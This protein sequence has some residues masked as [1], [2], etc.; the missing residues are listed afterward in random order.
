MTRLGRLLSALRPAAR[1]RPEAAAAPRWEAP[2]P[3]VTSRPP[4]AD[5][6][7]RIDAAAVR[8][9][10]QRQPERAARTIAAADRVLRHEFALL[11]SGPFVPRDPDR[12]ERAGYAPIDWRLD[13]VRGLRFP[14]GFRHTAW[15]LDAMRPGNA[16]VKLPW[17]L[18]RCQHW[19]VLAQAWLLTGDPRYAR[20]ILAQRADF[21]EANPA[22]Y[23]V[24]WAC[25]MDVGL[26]A[27]SWALA[28][29]LAG[30][31]PGDAEEW[32]AA[33]DSLYRH[34]RFIRGNLE[35]RYETTSNHFLANVV[36]LYYAA[37]VLGSS[38][39]VAE[40]TRFCREALEREMTVQVL[41]DGAD[42]ESSVPYHRLVTELFLGGARVS[43][44]AGAPLPA[45]YH[46]RLRDMVAFHLAVL[47]PDGRIPVIGDADDGRLHIA[48]DY[49]SWRPQDGLHLLGAAA[50]V[51]DAPELLA[52]AGGVGQ[53]EAFWWSAGLAADAP[54][55]ALPETV[56]LF[57]D[58]GLAVARTSCAYLVVTNGRVGTRGF[59]NHKHNE[60]LSFEYHLRGAPIVVD[61]G[62]YLYTPDPDARNRFRSTASHNTV[63]V[64]EVEQNEINPA[65]LFR[66]FEKADPVHLA[67][68]ANV[69]QVRYEGRHTGYVRAVPGAV[70]ER[71]FTLDR[72]TGA[73]AI[74]DR[75]DVPS[76]HTL[77]W[78]FHLDPGVEAQ[79][80]GPGTLLLRH[81]ALGVVCRLA[82]PPQLQARVAPAW[83]SPSYGVREPSN[84]VEVVRPAGAPGAP[85]WTFRLEP[86]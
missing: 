85:A 67:F 62:S 4:R 46:A 22:G 16:D 77:T 76:A 44:S 9:L 45:E 17:E 1:T 51:L 60:L 27:A 30:D 14:Q 63:Q 6:H 78:R 50:A 70:H 66:M 40:W 31:Y 68:E 73:L 2:G 35:D 83:Y 80:Q 47:R 24:Q 3:L 58:A 23:G 65:W 21:D 57:S 42:F 74:D 26:R 8:A 7:G 32:R 53:W 55:S 75:I 37:R 82:Y 39:E 64:D 33:Y 34:A 48:T 69:A 61:P 49:G 10:A 71:S 19:L 20:E 13:P 86:A 54:A 81:A 25:T 79:E 5:L 59:G 29:D 52:H 38:P 36:G 18:G 15:N 56:R 12:P 28:L 11:G 72:G 43:A 41:P 84:T